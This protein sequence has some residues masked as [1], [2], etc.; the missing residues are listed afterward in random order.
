MDERSE[1]IAKRFEVPMLIAATL[2]IPTII[3]EEGGPGETLETLGVVL[4]YAVW[5]AFVVEAVVMLWVVPNRWQWIREHPLEVIVVV[6]TPPF[7]L[8]VLEP[9]RLLRLLRLLRF[10]RLA[11]L[12]RRLLTAQGLR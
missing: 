9:I 2:V 11:P 4:N 7:F 5:T 12:V 10:V 1:H 8:T 3:I 6:L